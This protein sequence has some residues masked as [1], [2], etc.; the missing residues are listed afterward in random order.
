MSGTTWRYADMDEFAR[1]FPGQLAG[2]INAFMGSLQEAVTDHQDAAMDAREPVKTG[3]L[4]ASR[5]VERGGAG[6]VAGQIASRAGSPSKIGY[7]AVHA[8]FVV[9]GRKRSKK[10][11]RM[12]GSQQPQA[13]RG[14]I[15]GAQRQLRREWTKVVDIAASELNGI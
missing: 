12:L 6:R 5:Q 13:R 8:L 4:K 9:P 15:R 2:L 11:G 3:A 7:T 1:R 14:V 10:T